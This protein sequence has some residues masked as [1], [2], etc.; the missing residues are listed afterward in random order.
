MHQM[1]R[2]EQRLNKEENRM[3]GNYIPLTEIRILP[4]YS[5]SWEQ[6]RGRLTTS[7]TSPYFFFLYFLFYGKYMKRGTKQAC[8]GRVKKG[9]ISCNYTKLRL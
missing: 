8:N 2:V 9:S 4:T 7:L 5:T 1:T 6:G 3:S